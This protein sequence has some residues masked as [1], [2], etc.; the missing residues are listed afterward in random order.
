MDMAKEY[1]SA[2]SD[3]DQSM[4]IFHDKNDKGLATADLINQAYTATLQAFNTNSIT[5]NETQ[6]NLLELITAKTSTENYAGKEN[7]RLE[8]LEA[9]QKI[10]KEI[11]PENPY[12]QINSMN[13][14]YV[15][16][17]HGVNKNT[18]HHEVAAMMTNLKIAVLD[19]QISAEMAQHDMNVLSIAHLEDQDA[20]KLRGQLF[21]HQREMF[22]KLKIILPTQVGMKYKN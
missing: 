8:T 16:S 5:I 13:I 10:E 12:Q 7:K 19:N 20:V 3:A 4:K 21:E 14:H 11:F 6:R 17:Q 15:M 9:V 1:K 22:G 18:R 2:D